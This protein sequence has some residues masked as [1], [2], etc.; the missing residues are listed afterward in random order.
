MSIKL[1]YDEPADSLI[2]WAEIYSR[3]CMPSD[4]VLIFQAILFFDALIAE[5]FVAIFAML[6]VAKVLVLAA[7]ACVL[8]DAVHWLAQIVRDHHVASVLYELR[9]FVFQLMARCCRTPV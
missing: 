9:D 1:M 6:V 4:D 5:A 8:H 2:V 3:F 7:F